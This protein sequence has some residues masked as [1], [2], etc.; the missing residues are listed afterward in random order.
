[1]FGNLF[2]PLC[3]IYLQRGTFVQG[4]KGSQSSEESNKIGPKRVYFYWVTKEQESFEWFKGVM[5]DTAEH[6]HDVGFGTQ[7]TLA[8]NLSKL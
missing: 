4:L 3:G 1:M 5:D 6:D 7:N 8:A 2:I